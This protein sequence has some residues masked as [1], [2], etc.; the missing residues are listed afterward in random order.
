MHTQVARAGPASP[1]K[2]QNLETGSTQK[3]TGLFQDQERADM[4]SQGITFVNNPFS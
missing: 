1:R 3:L 4:V 2:G